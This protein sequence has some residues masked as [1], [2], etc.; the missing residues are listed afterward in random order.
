M[1]GEEGASFTLSQE[2]LYRL[3]L[4]FYKEQEAKGLQVPYQLRI[5]LVSLTQQAK[6][7]SFEKAAADLP[8]LGTFDII[9][10]ERRAAW[11]A[12]G[13]L[14]RE[15]S[16]AQ[17]VAKLLIAAPQFD[18]FIAVKTEERRLE[19]VRKAE[20]EKKSKEEAVAKAVREEERQVEEQQ[21]RAIQD[22]LNKQT[23]GQFRSY[24]EQQCPGNPDQQALLIKQLQEQHYYQY[25]QRLH[26]QQG[27]SGISG[28][29]Q[30]PL[31]EL[32]RLPEAGII[33]MNGGTE[34][35]KDGEEEREEET[36][37]VEEK[38]LEGDMATLTIEDKL[39]NMG[40]QFQEPE[41]AT[42]WTRK[43]I[44]VFKE[45]IRKEEGEA[46]LKIGHGETVTVRV[47]T[48]LDGRSLY[49]EF[50]TDGYDIGFG[51]FFEW[52]DPE[53]TQVTVHIS[54]SEDESE[55][56]ITDEEREEGEEGDPEM[57]A[58]RS[59]LVAETGPPTS[60]IIPTYR[61]D[62]HEEVYAGSHTYPRQGVYQLKFDN[63]YSLW[64]SKTLY[65]RVYYTR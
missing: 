17:F 22:A 44:N 31:Q 55:E 6:L 52:V 26:A 65:Y 8:P 30:V 64:R 48:H 2:E 40:G 28:D 63:S 4:S 10:K 62:C 25:M 3:G 41:E 15:E 24:A 16:K 51:L 11:E 35:T 7:G 18:D 1:A 33:E 53:D 61:R 19:E 9:G 5:E 56:Y 45:T 32:E 54:D 12:L 14:D 13:D 47:P 58:G 49:W 60:C 42:M 39:D 59:G 20:E 34:E 29:H 46:V 27:P 23:F 38:S 36:S 50:A 57:Q 21:R 43:E 37:L